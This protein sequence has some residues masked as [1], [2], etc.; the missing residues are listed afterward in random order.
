MF[1]HQHA[2][3]HIYTLF[4]FII[5]LYYVYHTYPFGGD[6]F[7]GTTSTFTV[8]AISRIPLSPS[9]VRNASSCGFAL[10]SVG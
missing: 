1:A 8:N 7:K 9:V 6:M 5:L 2:L 3:I 4:E 10:R